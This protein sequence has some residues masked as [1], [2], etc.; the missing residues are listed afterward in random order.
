MPTSD[1]AEGEVVRRLGASTQKRPTNRLAT[2]VV[3]GTAPVQLTSPTVAKHY[4]A[5]V[6]PHPWKQLAGLPV[7]GLTLRISLAVAAWAGLDESM[8]WTVM[9]KVPDAVG[10]PVMAPFELIDRPAGRVPPVIDQP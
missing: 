5:I 6:M 9:G 3:P 4:R 2:V 10:S 7:Q 8:T 1:E